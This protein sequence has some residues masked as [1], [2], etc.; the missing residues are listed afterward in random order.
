LKNSKKRIVVA[1]SAIVILSIILIFCFQKYSKNASPQSRSG[2]IINH[3]NR[4][5]IQKEKLGLQRST[6]TPSLEKCGNN[7]IDPGEVCDDG[8]TIDADDCSRNCLINRLCEDGVY[9]G[10]FIIKDYPDVKRFAGCISITGNLR[11]ESSKLT[12]IDLLKSLTHVEKGL[13]IRD[14]LSLQNI[15]GL[16]NLLSAGALVV[17]NNPVLKDLDGLSKLGEITGGVE[18]QRK[19]TPPNPLPPNYRP[20]H[21]RQFETSRIT[22]NT[23]LVNLSGLSNLKSIKTDLSIENNGSLVNIKGMNDITSINALSIRSN[24]NLVKLDGFSRLETVENNLDIENNNKL[25]DVSELGELSSINQGSLIL[26]SNP[27]LSDMAGLSNIKKIRQNLIIRNNDALTSLDLYALRLEDK[28]MSIHIID[29]DAISSIEGLGKLE[30]KIQLLAVSRNRNLSS[31]EGLNGITSIESRAEI[32]DNKTLKDLKGL[33]SLTSIGLSIKIN[34]NNALRDLSGLDSLTNIG[35]LLE[36]K[37]NNSLSNLDGLRNLERIGTMAIVL[38]NL[39]I[40]NDIGLPTCGA[41]ALFNRLKQ[42]GF[43][44]GAIICGNRSDTCGRKECE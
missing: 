9:R 36:I 37:G 19:T 15:D 41:T 26:E 39:L 24:P 16:R 17:Q 2:A 14:N 7:V 43:S 3:T 30:G 42:K 22:N 20:Y 27:R 21:I 25:E 18:L 6:E 40:M 4:S 31:L 10:D 12:D 23:S 13:Y 8:N 34:R 38:N 5:I 11:I 32:E 29:N 33:R 1:L 35:L 28:T 44:G